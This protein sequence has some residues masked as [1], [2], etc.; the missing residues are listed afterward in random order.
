M[1]QASRKTKTIVARPPD[2]RDQLLK[3]VVGENNDTE[4]IF[5]E[6]LFDHY[7]VRPNVLEK[8]CICDFA[9]WFEYSSYQRNKNVSIEEDNTDETNPEMYEQEHEDEI[10]D[11]IPAGTQYKLLDGSGYITKRK[12]KCILLYKRNEKDV[13]ENA[14]STLLLF[15]SFRNENLEIHTAD[16]SAVMQDHRDEIQRNQEKYEKHGSLFDDIEELEK[17][18]QDEENEQVEKNNEEE[19]EIEEPEEVKDFEKTYGDFENVARKE[20]TEKL[21]FEELKKQIRSLNIGQRMFFNDM[22]ERF[23]LPLGCLEPI[24]V[25]IQG[26]AGSGKSYLIKTLI[27]GVKYI[28]EKRKVSIDPKQPTVVVGAPTNNAASIIGGKTIH[29]LLGFGFLDEESAYIETNGPQ[30]KDLPWSF[31]NARLMVLD[32]ISMVGSNLFSKI[33]LRLQEILTLIPEW[34]FRSFGG[35]DMILLGDLYQL[36]PILDRYIFLNSTLRGRCGSL[37]KNHYQDNVSCYTLHEKMRSKEDSSFGHMCDAI[38]RES[39]TDEHRKMLKSRCNIHCPYEEDHENFKEGRLMVLALE[40][41][42]IQEINEDY[43]DRLNKESKIYTFKAKDTFAH[44][45]EQVPNIDR[46]YTECGNLP[47]T[48]RLKL[49]SPVILTKNISKADLLLNGKRGYLHEI[50]ED[51]MIC[52]VKFYEDIGNIA[53]FREKS[54]PKTACDKA[55]PIYLWKQPVSFHL[56]GKTKRGPIVS[57]RNQFPLVLAYATTVYKAQGLTLEYE[58]VDFEKKSKRA[59]PA[60]AFYTA[61]TRVK[62]LDKIFLRNFD[63]KHIRTDTRV[64]EQIQ[65]LANKPYILLK[66][67]MNERCFENCEIEHKLTFININGFNAHKDDIVSDFNLLESDVICFAE[68]KTNSTFDRSQIPGFQC[69]STVK[70]NSANSGGMA[71]FCKEEKCENIKII[72]KNQSKFEAGYMEFIKISIDNKIYTFLYLHPNA[73]ARDQNWLK[74]KMESLKDSSGILINFASTAFYLKL[75]CLAILGDFNLKTEISSDAEKMN[76][77]LPEFKIFIKGP[78][79]QRLDSFSSIDHV[80]VSNMLTDPFF[81]SSYRNIYSDHSAISFR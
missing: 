67:Y 38:A 7:S 33:S 52:W 62:A 81:C 19:L 50:D 60:G 65:K 75:L 47:T 45:S 16:L 72:D 48:L 4:D 57:R 1:V 34:K 11:K 77:M 78:T 5:V 40:N 63:D 58:I 55:T 25:H 70:A 10:L 42:I 14:V 74:D 24:L 69:I 54:R 36:P 26:C 66:R 28:T 18:F 68:T 51:K 22:L 3:P 61:V 79:F 21:S 6:G 29:S 76:Y 8:I 59:V 15:K 13:V 46:N 41:N 31:E 20:E 12:F 27:E 80:A 2:H 64:K 73:A 32:E 71:I 49:N 30:A 53:R 39:L 43:L 17:I 37:S 35:L 56:N 23:S 9:A 44:F